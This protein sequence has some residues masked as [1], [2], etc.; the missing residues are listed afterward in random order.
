MAHVQL[1]SLS[2]VQP[3][4]L[5][6]STGGGFGGPSR[7]AHRV[8]MIAF[9]LKKVLVTLGTLFVISMVIF[10]ATQ[11]LP[12]DAATHALGRNAT[13][14]TLARVQAELNLDRP[15]PTQ[16][17]LW[18]KGMLTGDLG[19]SVS[20]RVPV[21]DLIG[22]RILNTF[23]MVVLAAAVTLPLSILFGVV[24]A[25]R[26]DR[27]IDQALAGYAVVFT[28]VPDFVVG[29]ALLIVFATTVFTVLPGASLIPIGENPLNYMNE[30]VL[31]VATLVL[32]SVPYLGRLLRASMIDVLQS[33]YVVWAR[34]KG[35]PERRVILRHALPNA[36]VPMIQGIA[37]IL[38]YMSGGVVVIEYLFGFPGLGS[39]LLAAVYAR[40]VPVIQAVSLIFASFYVFI[41]IAADELSVLV[42]PHL[43]RRVS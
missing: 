29:I 15:M 35:V 38:A 1:E 18:M 39:S 24:G 7:A 2:S 40:D 10:A 42:T 8:G 14:E 27:A 6:A 22:S 5:R 31:P 17:W 23:T 20:A 12:G 34:L 26:R 32:V 41:N 36:L 13:P 11:V 9:F 19:T 25:M 3:E 21:A 33:E 30:M 4:A 28:A 43:R 37:L 16:Y